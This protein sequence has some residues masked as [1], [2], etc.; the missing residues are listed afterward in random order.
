[1]KLKMNPDKWD[2]KELKHVLSDL[3]S[4]AN[5]EWILEKLNEI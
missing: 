3:P 4:F 1:V 2:K 5:K